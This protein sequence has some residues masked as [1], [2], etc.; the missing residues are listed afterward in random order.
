MS[1]IKEQITNYRFPVVFKNIPN[2]VVSAKTSYKEGNTGTQSTPCYRDVTN[3]GFVFCH[4]DKHN[5]FDGSSYI[6]IGN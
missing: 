1:D 5:G 6:A 4:L 2:I 3:T